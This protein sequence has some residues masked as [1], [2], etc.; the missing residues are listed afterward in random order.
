MLKTQGKLVNDI[1]D[2][3]QLKKTFMEDIIVNMDTGYD[4]KKAKEKRMDKNRRYIDKLNG[5]INEA[6]DQLMEIPRKIREANEELLIESLKVCYETINSNRKE[7]ER[8]SNWIAETREEL[9]KNILIKHDMETSNRLIYSNMHDILGAEIIDIF[10]GIQEEYIN[11]DR[12]DNSK[13]E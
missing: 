5:K 3:K 10:D 2:M 7:L 13:K 4:N 1:E 12:P 9:K 11:E 8:I 6:Q